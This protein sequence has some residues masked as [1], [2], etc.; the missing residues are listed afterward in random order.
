MEQ[1][2]PHDETFIRWERWLLWIFASA[3][4]GG[5]VITYVLLPNMH[6]YSFPLGAALGGAIGG[7]LAG[8][9]PRIVQR[10]WVSAGVTVVAILIAAVSF[11]RDYPQLI[12]L[13][14]FLW[15]TPGVVI[16]IAVGLIM[17]WARQRSQTS[18]D[19]WVWPLAGILAV[20][21]T[22]VCSFLTM[23]TAAQ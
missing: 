5:L 17:R 20:L 22:S 1:S 11:F 2:S 15:V 9:M 8:L 12:F 19:W 10:W 4:G 3:T 13:Y 14:L 7:S 6:L 16:G 18:A 23:G 21:V